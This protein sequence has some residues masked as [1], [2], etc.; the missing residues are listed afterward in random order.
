MKNKSK[1][2]SLVEM[3]IVIAIVA[4]LVAV[5]VPIVGASRNKA[6]G[7]VDAA[8]IRSMMAEVATKRVS[9]NDETKLLDGM[10]IVDSEITP[11]SNVLFY[12][13][14]E[15]EIRA[16]YSTNILFPNHLRGTDY[17]GAVADTGDLD[18]PYD[19]LPDEARA[20]GVLTADGNAYDEKDLK[21]AQNELIQEFA[22]NVSRDVLEKFGFATKE[23]GS[24]DLSFDKLSENAKAITNL[25]KNTDDIEAIIKVSMVDSLVKDPSYNYSYD[26]AKD[27]IVSGAVGAA[28][29]ETMTLQKIEGNGILA[30]EYNKQVDKYNGQVENAIA[31]ITAGQEQPQYKLSSYYGCESKVWFGNTTWTCKTGTKEAFDA[32]CAQ[33]GLQPVYDHTHTPK[34]E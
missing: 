7:A 2:F 3:M 23:D 12:I 11:N 15:N 22:K 26:E 27:M 16:Y 33:Y 19:V 24:I 34:T 18:S 25:L 21:E 30:K 14:N 1:G 5:V 8:N 31:S 32:Y 13:V 29:T 10:S 4:I 9:E 6:K 17:N 28:F 20:L